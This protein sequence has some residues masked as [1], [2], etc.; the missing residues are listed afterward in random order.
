MVTEGLNSL[1]RWTARLP[2]F[3]RIAAEFALV[4]LVAFF[5]AKLAWL[6]I[7]PGPAVAAHQPRPLPTPLMQVN[8]GDVHADI[9]VLMTTNPF[10]VDEAAAVAV[11]NAPATQLN[12]KL[13]ALFMSTG[14]EID[15]AGSA[16]I[17]TPDNQTTRYELGDDI[18]PG[19]RLERILSDRVI[20]SRNGKE[21]TLMRGGRDE[22]LSVISDT[23]TTVNEPG[24]ASTTTNPV[25]RPDISVTT[26]IASL[27]TV[28]ETDNGRLTGLVLR[29]RGNPSVMQSAGLQPG[30]RL[31]ELNGTD[32]SELDVSGIAAEMGSARTVTMTVL[33]NGE[34]QPLEIA[35]GSE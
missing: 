14:D 25:F 19:V 32:V 1:P 7:A 24:R 21:E 23:S 2:V 20:I 3:A 31:I 27:E 18:L 9:S 10:Q 6:V 22:G 26:L 34:R 17:V 8:G 29:P 13:V 33:R 12:L 35:F 5:I 16:T 11:P 4:I 15:T 30:D 28:P